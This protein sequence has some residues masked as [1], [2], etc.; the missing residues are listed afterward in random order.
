MPV[1]PSRRVGSGT[2][3]GWGTWRWQAKK[4]QRSGRMQSQGWGAARSKWTL[5]RGLNGGAEERK[6][7]RHTAVVP[8][9]RCGA[10]DRVA[11]RDGEFAGFVLYRDRSEKSGFWRLFVCR[12]ACCLA[13]LSACTEF[14]EAQ[15]TGTEMGAFVEATLVADDFSGIEGGATPGRGFCGVA[16]EAAAAEILGFLAGGVVCELNGDGWGG[17]CGEEG[18]VV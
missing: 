7:E 9:A 11:T 4:K 6:R 16:V 8:I 5:E 3:E 1:C 14:V 13:C 17:G 10:R 15:W 12:G 2:F 18:G